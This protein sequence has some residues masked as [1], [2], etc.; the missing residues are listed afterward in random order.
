MK[1]IPLEER[2]WEKATPQG[3]CLLWNRGR[4]SCGYGIILGPERKVL[5]ASRVAWQLVNGQIPK[6]FCVMHKCDQPS[7]I[8]PKHL[9]LGTHADNMAD[10]AKKGRYNNHHENNPNHKLDWTIVK[11]IRRQ[12]VEGISRKELAKKFKFSSTL[13]QDVVSFKRWNKEVHSW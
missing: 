1:A 11:D 9:F 2:F 5:I 7:C 12:F 10:R 13:I 8:E 4:N 3:S 6:G